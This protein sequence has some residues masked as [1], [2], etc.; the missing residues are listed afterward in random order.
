MP[1]FSSTK[2]FIFFPDYHHTQPKKCVSSYKKFNFN[3]STASFTG[4]RIHFQCIFVCL[5]GNRFHRQTVNLRHF[6]QC[7]PDICAFIPFAPVRNRRQIRGIGFQHHPLYRNLPQHPPARQTFLKSQHTIDSYHESFERKQL[8]C[9][10]HRAA[11]AMENS[12][13]PSRT[14]KE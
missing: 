1:P 11:K 2:I 13:N 12:C 7:V 10:F 5:F 9:L 3:L 4:A 14:K 6:H 8:P